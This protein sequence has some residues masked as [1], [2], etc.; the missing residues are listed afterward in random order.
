MYALFQ[1]LSHYT[2]FLTTE[3]VFQPLVSN[4]NISQYYYDNR[5]TPSTPDAKFPRLSSASNNNNYRNNS[6]V[7]QDR[8]YLK[9]RNLEVYYDVPGRLVKNLGVVKGAKFY[10]Q[11]NDLFSFDKFEICDPEAYGTSQLYRSIVLGLRLRF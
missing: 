11:G 10:V 2:C 5:W 7:L 9:L 6:M 8:T 1:G 3:N 4:R